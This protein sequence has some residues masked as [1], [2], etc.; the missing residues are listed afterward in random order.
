[1]S[2]LLSLADDQHYP[3]GALY[4]VATPIGNTA[5]ITLRA[6]HVLGLVD[7]VAAED[8]RNSAHL[9]ARYGL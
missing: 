6:L 1:M 7:A 3:G 8:T 9:L 4:V 2:T 5:D